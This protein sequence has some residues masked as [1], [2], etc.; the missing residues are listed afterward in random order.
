VGGRLYGIHDGTTGPGA[1]EA[2][3]F[4]GGDDDDLVAAVNGDVLRAFTADTT[5]QLAEAGFG[6]LEDPV[7]GQA[8]GGGA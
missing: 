8:S 7:S 1:L 4:L 5:N 2:P 6:V 3:E